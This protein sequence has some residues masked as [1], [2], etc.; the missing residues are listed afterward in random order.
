MPYP[1]P[2]DS[3]T[4]PEA[5]CAGKDCERWRIRYLYRQK[6]INAYAWR[7]MDQIPPERDVFV[8]ESQSIVEKY[9]R[10]GPCADCMCREWCKQPC[11]RKKAW[12][13]ARERVAK[14]K[15]RDDT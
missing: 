5:N 14:K 6:Q 15:R 9:L 8:Y 3:C 4:A 10:N 2:C 12:M 11:S 1:S 13:E 7:L